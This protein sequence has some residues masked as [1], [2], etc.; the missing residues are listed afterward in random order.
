MFPPKAQEHLP[1][2]QDN[3]QY[4][5]HYPV[6]EK[7][8]KSDPHINS[9]EFHSFYMRNMK[10]LKQMA[11]FIKNPHNQTVRNKGMIDKSLYEMT[12]KKGIHS[13]RTAASGTVKTGSAFKGTFGEEPFF[14]KHSVYDPSHGQ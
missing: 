1:K 11:S 7:N 8:G 12:R 13:S 5:L 9:P 2:V 4:I 3:K 10:Y 6:K 14:E